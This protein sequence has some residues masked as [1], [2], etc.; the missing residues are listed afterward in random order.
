MQFY[1]ESDARSRSIQPDEIVELR[2][3]R[4]DIG[5]PFDEHSTKE[6]SREVVVKEIVHKPDSVVKQYGTVKAKIT[7]TQRS[8]VSEGDLVITIRDPKGSIVWNDRFTGEHEWKTEFSVY[9]GDER[10]LSDKDKSLLNT[11]S[12]SNT[13]QQ[14]QIMQELFKQIQNDLSYRLKNYYSRY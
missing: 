5:R 9:T 10:A 7:T 6:V 8:L 13:P 11:D 12:E 2:M 1:S 4:F 14:E 3:G